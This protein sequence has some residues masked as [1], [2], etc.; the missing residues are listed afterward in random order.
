[1]ASIFTH[2][3]LISDIADCFNCRTGTTDISPTANIAK[4]FGIRSIRVR[5]IAFQNYSNIHIA[6]LQRHFLGT[7]AC[8]PF[9]MVAHEKMS[10]H[11]NLILC[12]LIGKGLNFTMVRLSFKSDRWFPF[13]K[14]QD[15]TRGTT[16]VIGL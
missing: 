11:T 14:L 3:S 12:M 7:T 1:M 10:D 2:S 4:L 16:Y 13:G 6:L 15:T 9:S 8:L 5:G